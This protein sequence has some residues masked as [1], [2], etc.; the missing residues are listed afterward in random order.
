M[1][2]FLANS[3]RTVSWNLGMFTFKESS[4]VTVN[5][6]LEQQS[7][8]EPA[9]RKQPDNPETHCLAQ[10]GGLV[11]CHLVCPFCLHHLVIFFH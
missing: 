9:Q 6:N 5:K 8:C 1:W 3:L 7:L 4:V 10:M 2:A 11:G